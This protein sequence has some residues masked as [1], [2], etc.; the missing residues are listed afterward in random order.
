YWMEADA[1]GPIRRPIRPE[2]MRPLPAAARIDGTIIVQAVPD[3][4]GTP[5]RRQQAAATSFVRGVVGW[6]DLT[7]SSLAETL[8]AIKTSQGGEYLVAIRHQAHDE[9]DP[10]WLARPEVI[11]G[12]RT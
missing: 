7:S 3:A 8:E 11:A 6:A 4:G 12:I 5:D 2:D 9:E 1:L 10:E